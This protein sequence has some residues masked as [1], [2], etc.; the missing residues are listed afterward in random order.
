MS[1][2]I[3]MPVSIIAAASHAMAKQDIRYYLNGMMI[4]KS[5]HGGVRV[6]A[7]NGHHLIAL[8]SAKATI[9]QRKKAQYIVPAKMILSI[10][11]AAKQGLEVEFKVSSAGEVSA[12]VGDVTY[13]DKIIEA[14]YPEWEKTIPED[15]TLSGPVEVAPQYIESVIKAHTSLC[16]FEGRGTKYNGIRWH[17]RGNNKPLIATFGDALDEVDA[18]AVIMPLHCHT[19]ESYKAVKV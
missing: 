8:R 6:V 13:H 4:E 16:K 19:I 3:N 7:T 10:V 17:M 9:K 11:K 14:R 18:L 5:P 2:T 15:D 12:R 1:A